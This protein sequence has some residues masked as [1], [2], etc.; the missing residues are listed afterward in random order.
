M[1]DAVKVKVSYDGVKRRFAAN[2]Y[3]H[4]Q[5]T[6][7]TLYGQ[8][9][10][11]VSAG[12][13]IDSEDTLL[14]ASAAHT[15]PGVLSVEARVG[16]CSVPVAPRTPAPAPSDKEK[17]AWMHNT[18]G[19]Q[20]LAESP[21]PTSHHPDPHPH[22][23][24]E[25]W[26]SD[27]ASS[28]SSSSSP[29]QP[30][31]PPVR[32]YAQRQAKTQKRSKT[33]KYPSEYYDEA[34]GYCSY[35]D[36]EGDLRDG[37]EQLCPPE[38]SYDGFSDEEEEEEEDGDEDEDEEDD[39]AGPAPEV[40]AALVHMLLRENASLRRQL[41]EAR[42][43]GSNFAGRAA[44]ARQVSRTS[45]LSGG[46]NGRNSGGV[47]SLTVGLPSPFSSAAQSVASQQSSRGGAS[48][49]QQSVRSAK[50]VPSVRSVRSQQ[51]DP[52]EEFLSY[53]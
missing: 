6:V 24:Q 52:Y 33:P 40:E 47:L 49:V 35:E 20:L 25:V 16:R 53:L 22:R 42:G 31:P 12:V 23:P 15:G 39:L 19:S 3:E 37:G 13:V 21:T 43:A 7:D 45:P 8:S 36:V 29:I 34:E 51:S 9:C 2:S 27:V 10:V 11:L 17:L 28:S 4:L 48:R 1:S 41:R 38:G 46:R 18:A 50:S 5:R 26:D 14:T 30:T 32:T 44:S